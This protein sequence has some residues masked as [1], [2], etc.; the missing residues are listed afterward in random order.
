[1][2][3]KRRAAAIVVTAL[4]EWCVRYMEGAEPKVEVEVRLEIER[5]KDVYANLA[6]VV[7]PH[8]PEDWT[9]GDPPIGECNCD[10]CVRKKV[11]AAKAAGRLKDPTKEG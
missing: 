3:P 7:D 5:I 2:N 8:F 6:T 11:A 4:D 10:E 9:P 1:M